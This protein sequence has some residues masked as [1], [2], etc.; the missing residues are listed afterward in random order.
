MP[1]NYFTNLNTQGNNQISIPDYVNPATLNPNTQPKISQG[2]I[3]PTVSSVPLSAK[4]GNFFLNL[5]NKLTPILNAVAP[6]LNQGAAFQEGGIKGVVGNSF[7]NI[8]KNTTFNTD[9][10]KPT[11]ATSKQELYQQLKPQLSEGLNIA[12]GF[13]GGVDMESSNIINSLLKTKTVTEAYDI[14]SKSGVPQDLIPSYAERFAKANT[15]A[16]VQAGL[17]SLKSVMSNTTLGTSVAPEV[18]SLAQEALKYKTP[19][20]FVKAQGKPLYHGSPNT[21]DTFKVGESN[22]TKG[23]IYFTE[24]RQIAQKFTDKK[25]GGNIIE[26]YVDYKNPLEVGGGRPHPGYE[27]LKDPQKYGYDAIVH[28][29]DGGARTEVVVFDPKIIKTKSQLTDIWNKAQKTAEAVKPTTG[30][31]AQVFNTGKLNLTP[32]I[33]KGIEDRLS[34]LGLTTRN[35]RSFSDVEQ[36]AQSLGLDTQSLI[37]EVSNNRITDKEVVG[38]RNLINNNAQL[39]VDLQKKLELNPKNATVLNI[40][41]N[42]AEEELNAA[43]KKL[44]K[45]GTEAG[46]AVSAFRIMAQNT[47]DPQ[48]WLT[49][50]QKTLGNKTMTAEIRAGILDLIDKGDRQGLANFVSMLR[51]STLAEKAVTLWKAGLLTSPTTY[52]ANIIGNVGM[53]VLETLKDVP[54]TGFDILA[55]LFTGKRTT[56]ISPGT[57]TA[58]IKGLFKGGKEALSYLKTGIYPESILTKYDIPRTVNFNNKILNG[59]TQ[60]IFRS[61]GGED[62]IFRQAAL[63]ESLVKQA[64]VIAKND[65]LSGAL[66]KS[67]VAEL[68]QSPTN[69]MVVNAINEAEYSTFN[70]KNILST[71][72]SGAKRA[73]STHPVAQTTME[74]IAPFTKTPTNIAARIADYSPLGFFKA[75]LSQINPA[76]RG[77]KALVEDLSRALTGTSIIGIG[78]YLAL[79]GKLTGNAPPAGAARDQFY[80]EGKQPNA[81]NLWGNW[82]SLNR[83]SPLGNLLSIGANF[84]EAS[85]TKSGLSLGATTLASGIQGLAN[86]TFL[87]GVSGALGAINDTTPNQT[88]AQKYLESTIS[89]VIPT[90]IGKIART[91]DP[92]LRL[93]EGI[94]QTIQSKIPFASEALPVRR[95]VFGNPVKAGGGRLAIIDP[96]NTQKVSDNPIFKEARILGVNIGLSPQ[97][98]SGIKLTNSEYSQYQKVQGKILEKVLTALINN[99]AYKNLGATDKEKQFSNAIVQ[100]R[101]QVKDVVFPAMMINRYGLSPD[102]NPQILS[103]LLSVLSKENKFNQMSTEKQGNIIKKLLKQ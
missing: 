60:G 58:K 10:F 93:P 85:K 33:S 24:H 101:T 15:K 45:G 94:L 16:E 31:V 80:A 1:N 9:I 23:K 68:L 89:S 102:T 74:V 67:K 63:G 38:L 81:I 54:A 14:L 91:I 51:K 40:K 27:K 48:F 43:L 13:I 83:I 36:A 4:V 86:Q 79:H 30:K 17:N 7:N 47:L 29:D 32:E 61:L 52:M 56:T 5:G 88:N 22:I 8:V 90:V 87:Q 73:A 66:F 11:T 18:S 19:E 97:T 77:Q 44:V 75:I 20:E 6:N 35:V 59:Y 34:A 57:I 21:F 37:K 46:R 64:E 39:V 103:D 98:I 2:G 53:F 92:N 84:E 3:T 49:Q 25:R 76:T 28:F 26:S 65:K 42:K 41:I 99:N 62:L 100:S 12:A 95:D 72:I 70:N 96:F 78:S 50:A 55:S 82:Y 69:E 71:L